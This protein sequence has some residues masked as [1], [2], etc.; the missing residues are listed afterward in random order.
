[1]SIRRIAAA[2]GWVV[3][4]VHLNHFSLVVLRH[5]LRRNEVAITQPHFAPWRQAVILLGRVFAEI[6]LLDVQ[7]LGKWH[8]A[9]P[10]AFVLG[11]IDRLDLLN[12]TFRV[13]IDHDLQWPEHGHPTR[14]ALVEIFANEV[15]KHGKFQGAVSLRN[16]DGRAEIADRFRCITTTPHA[17]E[18]GHARII[19]TGDAFFLH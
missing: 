8:L 6:V 12:L 2:R 11:I 1:M 10:G 19:P 15:F 13:V 18:R 14:R 4:T 5:H 17:G 7:H 16:P 3:R 9:L